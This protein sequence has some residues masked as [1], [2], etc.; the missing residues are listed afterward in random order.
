M[1]TNEWYIITLIITGAAVP[2]SLL[3]PKKRFMFTGLGL[4]IIGLAFWAV[5]VIPKVQ[6]PFNYL[7]VWIIGMLCGSLIVKT[8]IE[9]RRARANS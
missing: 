4:G 2:L 7:M 1:T 9:F 8:A 3:S 5:Y 6:M